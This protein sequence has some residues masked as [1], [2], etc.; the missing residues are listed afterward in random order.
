MEFSTHPPE[1]LEFGKNIDDLASR[2]A[3]P[4]RRDL[5][6]METLRGT[7]DFN[8]ESRYVKILFEK[9]LSTECEV[10]SLE[11]GDTFLGIPVPMRA[12]KFQ[13]ELKKRDIPTKKE[14]GGI[15]VT[16][17]GVSFYVFEGETA[18]ICWTAMDPDANPK[19][20]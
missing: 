16:G 2:I 17:T 18:T 10:L 6:S 12:T 4:F 20:D 8:G 1:P 5:L 3:D 7:A 15:T 13:N 11:P 9:G 19:G 14:S